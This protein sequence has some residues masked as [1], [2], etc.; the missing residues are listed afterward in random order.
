MNVEYKDIP[1]KPQSIETV[2]FGVL[3]QKGVIQTLK[4]VFHGAPPKFHGNNRKLIFS[5]K[6]IDRMAEVYD[7]D[8]EVM[9]QEGE[10]ADASALRALRTD[11][12]HVG[13]DRHMEDVSD[14]DT[15]SN[16]SS[17]DENEA[18]ASQDNPATE[19]KK[20][21]NASYASCE[22]RDDKP[23]MYFSNGKYHCEWCNDT[24]DK[25]YMEDHKCSGRKA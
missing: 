9:V 16:E 13:L 3:S 1:F 21:S 4:E 6:I 17:Q 11:R 12:T 25:F 23:R 2:E 10:D 14:H 7:I 20:A 24:G 18:K 19:T 22:N 8:V 15:D 5:Q